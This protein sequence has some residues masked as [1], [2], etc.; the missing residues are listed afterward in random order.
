MP[1]AVLHHFRQ[2]QYGKLFGELIEH[3]ALA[4]VGRIQARQFDAAH[5]IANVQKPAR[6]A[7]LSIHGE[8][9]SRRGLHA[10]TVQHRAKDVVVIE[11]VDQRFVQHH[12]VGH[13]SVHH[14]LV[15]IG[16]AQPPNLA[17][18][19][20]VVA[21][22]H[23]GEVIKRARLFGE[24]NNV[25]PPVVLDADIAFLDIDIRRAVLAHGAELHQVAIGPEF[26]SANS[27]LS[28]PTTLLT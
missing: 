26:L 8:R 13:G 16:G 21:V 23:L 25:R 14:A 11:A 12:F 10:E 24:G 19:H 1:A 18:E 4:R 27:R 28:V 9:M 22:M 17:G 5:R 15:Q 3:P 20:D 2:F 6:L 7:A